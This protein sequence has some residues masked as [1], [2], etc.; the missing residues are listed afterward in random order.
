M[1]YPVHCYIVSISEWQR[2]AY[3]DLAKYY[4]NKAMVYDKLATTHINARDTAYMNGEYE[5]SSKFAV[6]ANKYAGLVKIYDMYAKQ[7]KKL[8]SNA[9][10]VDELQKKTEPE[11]KRLLEK[12]A[13][14]SRR[15]NI[16]EFKERVESKGVWDYKLPIIREKE[17]LLKHIKNEE[18]V[19][20]NG[21]VMTWEEFGNYHYG[22]VGA[23]R[24]MGISLLI[25]GSLHAAKYDLDYNEQRDQEWVSMG[26][27]DYK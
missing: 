27:D 1:G 7:Y 3:A 19:Y 5:L 18:Y 15:G 9:K 25:V 4:T 8:A 14:I 11:L 23:A 6:Y 2:K 22:Y 12:N 21:Y 20:F 16:F 13:K 10:D 17:S 26:H 24:G